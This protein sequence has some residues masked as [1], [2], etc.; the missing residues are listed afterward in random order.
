VQ[1]VFAILALA[2]TLLIFC[3]P[4]T[5]P[6][7]RL[8]Q[9]LFDA[10]WTSA[11][12][13]A[14]AAMAV[15]ALRSREVTL[16][17]PLVLWLCAMVALVAL[18]YVTGRLNYPSQ[19]SL[20][21]VYAI[22]LLGAYW[23]GRALVANEMRE[24]A[25]VA[26]AA[27]LL[28]GAIFSVAIQWLQLLDVRGLP[29]WLYFEIDDPWYRTRPFAN[30]GQANHLATYLV[31]ALFATLFLHRRP[32]PPAATLVCA[33][34]IAIGLA[35]TRSR[36]GVVFAL[37]P[38]AACWLPTALRPVQMRDR[39]GTSAALVLG[40]IVGSFCVSLLVAYQGGA[41]DTALA[42]F[43]ESGGFSIRLTMW[44]DAIRV[45]ANSP[46]LGTGFDQYPF[47]Q[48][49]LAQPGRQQISTNNV[50]NLVLQTAAELGWPMAVSL[51]C[52]AL[53]WAL[54]GFKHRIAERH[55][56]FA[57]LLLAVVGA[58]ALLE[59]P[60]SLL[61]FA[62]PAALLFALAEPDVR[63]KFASVQ[64]DARLLI[65]VGVCG[66]LLAATMKLEFDEISEVTYRA[67]AERRTS[68][69][70][71]EDTLR[72]LVALGQA[73]LLR[74]YPELLLTSLRQPDLVEATDEEIKM[75]ERVMVR[76]VDA[77]LIARLTILNAKAGHV[78]ESVRHAERLAIFY[79]DRYAD[80]SRMILEAT[81][82]L[83]SEADP[84][85]RQL[86]SGASTPATAPA[87]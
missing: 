51:V 11:V 15:G 40:Y 63:S 17:L 86:A 53:W 48:Y 29:G 57:W 87:R 31:W 14:A 76:S 36:M 43:N 6:V 27:G 34:V 4:F 49:W 37:A 16:R 12:L 74:A 21:C 71:D 82:T 78:E 77:R 50:H 85:R 47:S 46:W 64:L 39:I 54:A 35:L 52:L 10:E 42:R 59:W 73:S 45:A 28:G 83:G 79:Q 65:G 55:S 70:V 41:V 38:L 84:L 33:F 67:D 32:L 72:R 8:P 1:R 62:I 24:R 5:L 69:G 23:L 68:K 22:A 60:L 26:I 80:L 75:H 44:A 25:L 20:A 30:L 58:H 3:A 7:H 13:L 66:L 19:L 9:A 81:A 18:Q 2:L 56:A 61:H